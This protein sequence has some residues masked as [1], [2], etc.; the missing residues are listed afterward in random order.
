MYLST[1][2]RKQSALVHVSKL[3]RLTWKLFS[4]TRN[5]LDICACFVRQ[6]FVIRATALQYQAPASAFRQ[7]AVDLPESRL[8]G[9][10]RL[11]P[12]KSCAGTHLSSHLFIFDCECPSL[13][14]ETHL[15]IYAAKGQ[16]SVDCAR[17][18]LTRLGAPPVYLR[19]AY[20]D[21][22]VLL[23]MPSQTL[24]MNRQCGKHT[25]RMWETSLSSSA[26]TRERR[27][28]IE[29][30]EQHWRRY[31]NAHE[32]PA[33]RLAFFLQIKRHMRGMHTRFKQGSLDC[34]CIW[35]RKL[36]LLF[37]FASREGKALLFQSSFLILEAIERF[38]SPVRTDSREEA[39]Y[40]STE[41]VELRLATAFLEHTQHSQHTHTQTQTHT[42][43]HT[44]TVFH[45]IQHT[46]QTQHHVCNTTCAQHNIAPHTL[47]NFQ[48]PGN[49]RVS[50]ARQAVTW[51][52][53]G[54]NVLV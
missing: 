36:T 34:E 49:S 22:Q 12:R 20:A 2:S 5:D 29:L 42:R 38:A 3:M 15:Q 1:F 24:K 51:A 39:A 45:N 43:A 32:V 50:L 46:A 31:S 11:V 41:K 26:P 52:N 7:S 18:Q 27:A 40:S 53:F 54:G 14:H 47:P 37:L 16:L 10:L 23:Y 35:A 19:I 30:P 9:A 44:H 17:Q 48:Q 25:M 4:D 21:L 13:V 8:R 6:M 28:A 33:I